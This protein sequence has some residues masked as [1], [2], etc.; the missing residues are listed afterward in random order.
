MPKTEIPRALNPMH[1]HGAGTPNYPETCI[2]MIQ[3]VGAAGVSCND[4]ANYVVGKLDPK[5]ETYQLSLANAQRALDDLVY[6]GV[7]CLRDDGR[8]YWWSLCR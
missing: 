3:R 7:A 6:L 5:N 2:S 4:V 1:T 8:Y